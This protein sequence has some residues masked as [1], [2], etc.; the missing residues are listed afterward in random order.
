MLEAKT[1]EIRDKLSTQVQE[2]QKSVDHYKS[3]FNNIAMEIQNKEDQ[4]FEY[5]DKIKND[6]RIEQNK[7]KTL[8]TINQQLNTKIRDITNQ[9]K[10]FFGKYENSKYDNFEL[11]HHLLSLISENKRLNE[12]LEENFTTGDNE[13]TL[14]NQN[15]NRSYKTQLANGLR[16]SLLSDQKP[17]IVARFNEKLENSRDSRDLS[18]DLK[19]THSC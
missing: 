11:K 15:T 9:N 18:R 6:I 3:A 16:M 14:N 1:H 2:A 5:I 4:Y 12:N 17:E 8:E 10:T 7:I 19:P 13:S